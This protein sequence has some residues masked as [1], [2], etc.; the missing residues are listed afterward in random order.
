MGP[1]IA[2]RKGIHSGGLTVD[3]KSGDVLLFVEDKH[4][5][6]PLHM[7]RS[8]DHGE[9]WKEE[10]VVVKPD[11]NGNV[12]SM[13][14]AEHGIALRHGE[15]KG[16]LLRPTRV[17]KAPAYNNA[18]YSD[19]GGK[20]WLASGPFP[21]MGTGEGA[22]AE[23][24]NGHIYYSSRNHRFEKEADFTHKRPFAWSTDGGA[25]W[26]DAGYDDEL[27]DGPRYRGNRRGF[28]FNGHFGMMCGLTRL[29][30]EG[31][32]ILLYSNADTPEHNRVRMT[33]WAS[34]DG[35]KTWPV[36]RLVF[37]GPAAYSS[38]AAGRPGTPSEGWIYLQF[39]GGPSG[40]HSDG[41]LARF[42]LSWLLEGEKT[43]DGQLPTWVT[44]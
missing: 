10:E 8:V 36:K 18:I 31:R 19:D 23:L 14:M 39:E 43:G 24:S 30:V 15:H 2:I 25:T 11:V 22:V 20:T 1:E 13:H 21:I 42:N 6:A 29:P 17:Y 28:N 44:E 33:V 16:R 41:Q 7:F 40:S 9:S 37:D 12:P 35:A 4:P 5:P 26:E 38:L 3:E 27:P 32:D 34:F